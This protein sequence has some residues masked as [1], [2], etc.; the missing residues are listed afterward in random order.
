MTP[1]YQ[2]TYTGE[3][4]DEGILKSFS[5]PTPTVQDDGKVIIVDN[6]TYSLGEVSGGGHLYQHEIG[7]SY[8]AKL[9]P[10]FSPISD[11]IHMTIVSTSAEPMTINSIGKMLYDMG[12]SNLQ[13]S[14]YWSC[15]CNVAEWSSSEFGIFWLKL[16][17]SLI[18]GVYKLSLDGSK[19]LVYASSTW[20]T[21][22]EQGQ[23]YIYDLSLS[24][25]KITQIQ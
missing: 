12:F 16:R 5:I 24:F 21:D 7:F 10:H 19:R 17:G 14:Y 25:D 2:S 9:S 23:G 1:I 20:I 22:T 15:P 4:I 8:N 6:G 18:N 13:N 11:S 3:Q